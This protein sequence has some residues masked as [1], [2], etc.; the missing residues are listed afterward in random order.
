LN[1]Q[2]LSLLSY[3]DTTIAKRRYTNAI[4]EKDHILLLL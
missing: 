4:G 3:D 1:R 2:I